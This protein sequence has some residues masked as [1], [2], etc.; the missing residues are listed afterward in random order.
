M[1]ISFKT[2]C[3]MLAVTNGLHL[4]EEASRLSQVLALASPSSP[5]RSF[6]LA[7]QGHLLSQ[8]LRIRQAQV[9]STVTVAGTTAVG[10]RHPGAGR[11]LFVPRERLDY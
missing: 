7:R 3:A 11:T 6:L 10:I 4:F 2:I 8:C 9:V 5:A 1:R